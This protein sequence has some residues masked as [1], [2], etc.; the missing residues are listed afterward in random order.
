MQ[1]GSPLMEGPAQPL[2][3]GLLE[4]GIDLV[5]EWLLKG[6]HLGILVPLRTAVRI[7][8]QSAPL[9]AQLA[10]LGE[11]ALEFD[12]WGAAAL[13]VVAE[14]NGALDWL[15]GASRRC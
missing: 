13:A 4:R 15:A 12:V 3:W 1:P 8:V 5:R 6:W 9:W 11:A 7:F 10:S 14:N 2:L